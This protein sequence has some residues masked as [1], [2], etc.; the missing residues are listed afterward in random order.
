MV[1]AVLLVMIAIPCILAPVVAPHDPFVMP[2]PVGLKSKPPS[3][4]YLMGTDKYSR[5][6]LSRRRTQGRKRLTVK[7]PSTYAAAYHAPAL[8]AG[9]SHRSRR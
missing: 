8:F 9:A 3:D 5:D 1:A 7:L 2:D 6:V 4:L